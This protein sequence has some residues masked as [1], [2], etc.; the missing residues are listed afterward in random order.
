MA[1][2]F[3]SL[4]FVAAALLVGVASQAVAQTAVAEPVLSEKAVAVLCAKSGHEDGFPSAVTAEISAAIKA[5]QAKGGT[6][7]RAIERL[8]VRTC[9]GQFI[10]VVAPVLSE[11]AV[12][13]LCAKSGHEDGFP[14]AVTAEISG[15]VRKEQ[16]KGGTTMDAIERLYGR[17]CGSDFA[18]KA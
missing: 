15:A 6:T 9:G 13:I 17:A 14:S 2:K 10:A 7:V 5:E 18:K 8:S 12:A 4:A 1:K 16:V 11:K 3:A